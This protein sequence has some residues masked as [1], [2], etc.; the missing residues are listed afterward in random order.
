[1]IVSLENSVEAV[2]AICGTL[3]AG[4]VIV[5]V[6][7]TTKSD[8]LEYL[9]RDS[10]PVVVIADARAA[11]TISCAMEKIALKPAVVM[12]GRFERSRW[13]FASELVSFEQLREPTG[14]ARS[15]NRGIDIDV[16]A[17]IYT[18]GS[19]GGPKGVMLSHRNILSA[20]T[21]INAYLKNTPEDVILDVLPLSFDYGLYPTVSRASG[22][23]QSRARAFVCVSGGDAGAHGAGEGHRVADGA[24]DCGSPV[25]TISHSSTC[26]RFGTSRTRAPCCRPR[27][28]PSCAS[29]CLR[30][31]SSRCTGLTECKRVS[32]LDPDELDHRPTSVGKPMDNV[33]VFLV[34]AEGTRI[35]RG[36]G[37]L[38][39]RGSNV[40]QG[41]WRAPEDTARS[42]VPG[43][44]PGERVLR[45][46]DIFTIDDDGFMYLQHRLD[47]VIK[48]RGQKV[49]P[50]EIEDV[51]H[52]APGVVEA[53]VV[54]RPDAVMGEAL[55]GYVTIAP[56]AAVT[57][58]SLLLYLFETCRGL[59]GAPNRSRSS[60]SCRTTVPAN[61]LGE[62]CQFGSRRDDHRSVAA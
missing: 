20:T 33:E 59:H 35:D 12:T 62:G 26:P 4:G 5:P 9:I 2:L 15:L 34:D 32:F 46:G 49:S 58:R 36:T 3:R 27:T 28:L 30:R 1:M 11:Q 21:S 45:T 24:D 23:R 7:P 61:C 52:G 19:T 17:L 50:R 31:D 6:N 14:D 54:G 29:G 51:L 38:F 57:E 13:R 48:S 47:E 25:S 16:A 8:K 18:S 43:L 37:E 10:E 53:L 22:R 60:R 42:L 44:L 40:M 56:G 55:H 39:V 41:Y